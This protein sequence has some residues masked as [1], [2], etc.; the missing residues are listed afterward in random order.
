MLSNYRIE[1]KK[2]QAI[3]KDHSSSLKNSEN[4]EIKF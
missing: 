4:D 1:M 3:G 2:L